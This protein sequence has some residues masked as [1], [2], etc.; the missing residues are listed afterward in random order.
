VSKSED[1][2]RLDYSKFDNVD[3]ETLEAYLQADFNAP[4]A[5]QMEPEAIFYILNLLEERQKDEQNESQEDEDASADLDKFYSDYYSLLENEQQFFD[6]YNEFGE[7]INTAETKESDFRHKFRKPL[8]RFASVVV[9]LVILLGVGTVTSYALGYNPWAAIGHWNDD[10]FWLETNTSV[11]AELADTVAEYAPDIELVPKW[12]P[13]G[14][15]SQEIKVIKSE[16]FTKVITS[17]Y[18]ESTSDSINELYLDYIIYSNND[19]VKLYEKDN[20]DI[21]TFWANGIKH[22]IMENLDIRT[23]AWQNKNC[24]GSIKGNISLDEAHKIINSIY[25]E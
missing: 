6:F 3:S 9:V 13:N 10:N 12:L 24:E 1:K 20:I 11:T 8:R 4:E 15:V 17:F 25:E 14:Y 18:K 5:E 19:N 23:I 2:G 16:L 7:N 22:Y 21:I